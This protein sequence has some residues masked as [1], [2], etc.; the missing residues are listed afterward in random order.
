MRCKVRGFCGTFDKHSHDERLH[1]SSSFFSFQVVRNATFSSIIC[2]NWSKRTC[3][4]VHDGL[5]DGAEVLLDM[6][7]ES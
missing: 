7:S 4:F 2:E 6:A 1:M 5:C 3:L